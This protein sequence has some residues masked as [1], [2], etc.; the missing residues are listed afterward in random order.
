MIKGHSFK[1]Q[2]FWWACKYKDK[3]KVKVRVCV[4]GVFWLF[5][6]TLKVCWGVIYIHTF[7][8]ELKPD[9]QVPDCHISAVGCSHDCMGGDLGLK[10]THPA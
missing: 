10:V 5:F 9:E 4:V 6:I 7:K 1:I 2:V 3:I 8:V